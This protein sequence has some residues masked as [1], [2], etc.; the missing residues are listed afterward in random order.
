MRQLA[1]G[2]VRLRASARYR[3]PPLF[4]FDEVGLFLGPQAGNTGQP[5]RLRG[6]PMALF[7]QIFLLVPSHERCLPIWKGIRR[8]SR[9][10][11]H[12]LGDSRAAL[13]GA[14]RAVRAGCWRSHGYPLTA[15]RL[16]LERVAYP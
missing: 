8:D 4:H 3:Q 1:A 16:V 7:D 10:A 14:L 9:T 13:P 12:A 5:T 6:Q 15:D 11:A 2:G